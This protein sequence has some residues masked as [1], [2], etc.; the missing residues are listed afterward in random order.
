MGRTSATWEKAPEL[1]QFKMQIPGKLQFLMQP[2]T[3]EPGGGRFKVVHGGRGSA[4]SMSTAKANL[5]RAFNSRKK[6]LNAREI[7]NSIKDSV[8]ALYKECIYDMRFVEGTDF[9]VQNDSIICPRTESLFIFKGLRANA[10]EIK[11]MQGIDIAWVEEA[12]KVS[13]ASWKYLVPTIRAEYEDGSCSEIIIT[14]N[15]ELEE[16]YTY[17]NFIVDPPSSAIVVQMNWAD[18]PWFPSVLNAERVEL[19]TKAQAAK[20]RGLTRLMEEYMWIWEGHTKSAVEGAIYAEE[21]AVAQAE[22]R[23]TSVPLLRGVPV[24]TYWDLGRSD[25]TA[26]WFVQYQPGAR[27]VVDYYENSGLAIDHYVAKLQEKGYVYGTHYL[28]HDADN[29]VIQASKSVSGQLRDAFPQEGAVKVVR[30]PARKMLGINAGR[31]VMSMALIDREA[32]ADG[33]TRLRRYRY[34]VK[35]D[36]ARTVEPLHD[37]NS[38]G[39]DA[40]QTFGLADAPPRAEGKMPAMKPPPRNFTGRTS[41]GWMR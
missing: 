7:Q 39:A 32:C 17:Q 34:G 41:T 2:A 10:A 23:I 14:M 37:E 24:N 31:N 6:I 22:N 29:E 30:R 3:T 15:P 5:M 38:N 33:L 13:A 20:E 18:N 8:H 16:D 28:P 35:D 27:R 21:L 19:F 1:R 11:S 40:W 9:V 12:D 25:Q 26:I 36:G 4:K